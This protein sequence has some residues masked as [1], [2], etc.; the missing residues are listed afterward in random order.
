MAG[1]G[2]KGAV[3]QIARWRRDS[4]AGDRGAA[5]SIA[6]S[7]S[8]S[9]YILDS[10]IA[11]MKKMAGL[12]LLFAFGLAAAN[13]WQ[14]PYTE[15]S[16][17]DTTKMMTDSPWAKSASVSMGGPGG[18]APP[19]APPGGGGFGRGAPGGPQGGGGAEFGPGAQGS[20]APD[21]RC[22]GSLAIRTPDPAG[23]RASQVRRRSGQIGRSW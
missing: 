2:L 8:T 18:G 3:Y 4:L 10:E 16:D 23:I 19:A 6:Y 9:C 21:T 1:F 15:W 13:F 17:K 20:G 5:A 22:C 11:V 14:K 12:F 7:W